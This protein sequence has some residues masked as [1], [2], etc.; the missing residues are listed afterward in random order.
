LFA[1]EGF[2]GPDLVTDDDVGNEL[3]SELV[4]PLIPQLDVVGLHDLPRY[5]YD[6]SAVAH[7]GADVAADQLAVVP[8]TDG[9]VQALGE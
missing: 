9:R 6:A 1:S 4:A 7:T 8:A 5:P 2:D 3:V